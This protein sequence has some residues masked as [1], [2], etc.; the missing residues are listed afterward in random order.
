M[1]RPDCTQISEGKLQNRSCY[2]IF[3]Y[4]VSGTDT[5]LKPG[6]RR[7]DSATTAD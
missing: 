6:C 3:L 2:I 5:F 1:C 7:G 4:Y